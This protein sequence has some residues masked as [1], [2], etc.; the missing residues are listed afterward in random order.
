MK[1]K[2]IKKILLIFSSF[3]FGL[4]SSA[5]IVQND[6]VKIDYN[7]IFAYCLDGNITPALNILEVY[8]SQKLSLRDLKFKTEFENR[9]KYSE[10]KSDFLENRKSPI[11]ELLK[12]YRDYWRLS[13]LDNSKSYDSLLMRNLSVFFSSMYKLP[14]DSKGILQED[15]IDFYLKK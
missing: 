8:D 4:N 11:N 1:T 3:L 5:Q 10:D 13:L 12:I 14:L 9:F 7:K 2:N 15:T 6:G